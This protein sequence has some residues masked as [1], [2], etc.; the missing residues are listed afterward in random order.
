MTSRVSRW[1]VANRICRPCVC[2]RARVEGSVNGR[3]SLGEV[4][5]Q[6]RENVCSVATPLR[7]FSFSIEREGGREWKKW[8]DDFYSTMRRN[9]FRRMDVC[10]TGEDAARKRG[11][12]R[13]L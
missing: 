3:A 10:Y 2:V 12:K 4:F 1:E 7:S 8:R 11:H 5:E 13:R 6:H 9:E